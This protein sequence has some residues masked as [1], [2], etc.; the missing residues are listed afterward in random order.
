MLKKIYNLIKILRKLS[1]SGAVETLEEFKPLPKTLKLIF[2]IFSLGSTNKT[3]NLKKTSGEKLC[4]SL[5]DMGTTFIKLGQFLATRPDIIGEEVSKK[6]EK[7]QDKL[8]AFSTKDAKIILEREIGSKSFKDILYLSDPVAA[9]SIAQVHFAKLKTQ[10]GEKEVAIKIL[11]P[12]IHALVNDE[13]DALMFLA[14]IVE[15]IFIKTKRL[16][17]VEIINLLKEITN[18][19]MDLRFEAAAASELRENTINDKG[20]E[21]PKIYWNYTS[22]EVMAL[23]K[24][25]GVSIR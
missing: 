19:E 7:L 10:E 22:K 13:L 4:Q 16:K 23:D 1:V 9:A 8:P 5:E 21:V 18:V 12:N 15:S 24:I 25:N 6:L 11:R 17:L 20:I 2:F 3:S 14:Y